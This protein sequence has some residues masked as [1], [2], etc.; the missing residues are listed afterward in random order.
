MQVSSVGGRTAPSRSRARSI[1]RQPIKSLCVIDVTQD[2]VVGMHPYAVMVYRE[3]P[4]D[5]ST[6]QAR[7]RRIGRCARCHAPV[8]A[9]EE[10]YDAGTGVVHG[11]CGADQAQDTDQAD[12]SPD[13]AT[14]RVHPRALEIIQTARPRRVGP[15]ATSVLVGFGR[16]A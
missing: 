12:P 9:D 16:R 13:P 1:G 14:A 10:H 3:T 4:L 6:F 8:L 7:S 15:T 5:I 2:P 11:A